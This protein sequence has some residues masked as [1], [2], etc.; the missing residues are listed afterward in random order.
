MLFSYRAV[1]WNGLFFVLRI[2][3]WW[4][5]FCA[6]ENE[7]QIVALLTDIEEGDHAWEIKGVHSRGIRELFNLECFTNY[8]S[9][10][11]SFTH[12]KGKAQFFLALSIRCGFRVLRVFVVLWFP[13][14]RSS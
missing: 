9:T 3:V 7:D 6:K 1:P 10:C 14:T 2:L 4:W 5:G 8:E 13:F 12:G 11:A